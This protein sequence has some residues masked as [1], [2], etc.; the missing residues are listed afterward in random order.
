[1]LDQWNKHRPLCSVGAPKPYYVLLSRLSCMRARIRYAFFA[2]VDICFCLALSSRPLSA[3]RVMV[4]CSRRMRPQSCVDSGRPYY[5]LLYR[6][7]TAFLVSITSH[8]ADTGFPTV[9]HGLLDHLRS[10]EDQ[11]KFRTDAASNEDAMGTTGP[12]RTIQDHKIL[13]WYT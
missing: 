4:S 13:K 7:M 8:H 2:H 6:F 11:I 3:D 12:T 9:F 10:L 5:H 1:M